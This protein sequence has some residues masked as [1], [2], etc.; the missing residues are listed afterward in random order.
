MLSVKRVFR[1]GDDADQA[2]T[3]IFLGMFVTY[4]AQAFLNTSVI[5]VA[6]YFWLVAGLLDLCETPIKLINKQNNK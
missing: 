1:G 6:M 3:W 2:Y 5:N 4:L